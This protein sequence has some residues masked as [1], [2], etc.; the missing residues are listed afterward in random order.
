LIGSYERIAAMLDQYATI[1]GVSGVMLTFD[2][3]VEGMD[4]FGQSIQPLMTTRQHL[5]SSQAAA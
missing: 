2:D 1:P 4:K 3:F 5:K